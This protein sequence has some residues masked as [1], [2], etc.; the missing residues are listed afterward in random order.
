MVLNFDLTVG[1][2]VTEIVGEGFPLP[3]FCR[4]KPFVHGTSRTPSPT[5][6][7]IKNRSTVR[8]Y[9]NNDL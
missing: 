8:K 1:Y 2:D 7:S 4:S 5:D 3:H 6:K 9:T